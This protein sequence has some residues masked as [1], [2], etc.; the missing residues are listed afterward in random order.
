[1]RIDGAVPGMEIIW[2]AEKPYES[3]KFLFT[4]RSNQNKRATA[5]NLNVTLKELNFFISL[6]PPV[7]VSKSET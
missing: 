5:L 3:S 4:V 7:L 6:D 1:M 2:F